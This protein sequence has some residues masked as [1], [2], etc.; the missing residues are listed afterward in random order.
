MSSTPFRRLAVLSAC[1]ALL[2]AGTLIQARAV[3]SD[4][5][6]KVTATATRPDAAGNQVVTLNLDIEKPWHLYANPVGNEDLEDA[7]TVVTVGAREKPEPVKVE[8]PEGKLVKDPATKDYRIYEGKVTIKAQVRRAK[9]DT[10]PLEVSIQVQACKTE[11]K[12][13]ACLLPA[14]MK[15]QVP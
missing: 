3:K 11:G 8:Y 12:S 13:G 1:L 2:A 9:G 4:S 15:V 14:T 10:S 5:V 6:V 7:A